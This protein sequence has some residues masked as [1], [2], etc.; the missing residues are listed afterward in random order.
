L[1]K[2][3]KLYFSACDFKLF[4]IKIFEDA[5]HLFQSAGNGSPSEYG[6]LKKEFTPGFLE[7]IKTWILRYVSPVR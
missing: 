1:S 7:Y 4:E 5:N 2:Y 3:S 6:K